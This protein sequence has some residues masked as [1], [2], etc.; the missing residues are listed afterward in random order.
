MN[1]YIRN[2]ND[3][4]LQLDWSPKMLSILHITVFSAVVMILFSFP[5]IAKA[6]RGYVTYAEMAAYMQQELGDLPQ[7]CQC[8][9]AEQRFKE[10]FVLDG[11]P[12]PKPY[13][14]MRNKW[15]KIFKNDWTYLHHYCNGLMRMNEASGISNQKTV[16]NKEAV[17]R[18][19][20]GEFDF[21]R[22]SASKNFPLLGQLYMYQYQIYI[23]LNEPL[24]AQKALLRAQA[25]KKRNKKNSN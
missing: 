24:K 13:E 21:I 4:R 9:K 20:I 3:G 11:N 22:R 19:A 14:A 16:R 2:D 1:I 12:W 5:D 25:I 8:R 17:L 23:Q 15:I 10:D 7:Y 6:E 18:N